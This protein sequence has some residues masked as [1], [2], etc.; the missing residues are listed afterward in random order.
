M[1]DKM[2]KV[3]NRYGEKIYKVTKKSEAKKPKPDYYEEIK[4]T[5]SMTEL[6]PRLRF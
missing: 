1:E 6:L 2:F 3:K 5:R 4:D